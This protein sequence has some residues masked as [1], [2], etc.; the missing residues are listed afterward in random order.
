MPRADPMRETDA[1]N[2]IHEYGRRLFGN[3]YDIDLNDRK[4]A[5]WVTKK[6]MTYQGILFTIDY[7]FRVLGSS[8]DE[9]HNG[10]G[11]VPYVYNDAREYHV[12]TMGLHRESYTPEVMD[13]I[14]QTETSVVN[15]ETQKP[16]KKTYLKGFELK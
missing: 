10:F 2:K 15:V 14:T 12:K 5:S 8:I 3:A 9:A 13:R 7:W 16:I 11:I 1:R 6:D 4:I